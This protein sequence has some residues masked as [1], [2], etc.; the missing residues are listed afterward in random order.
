MS[1]RWQR[2]VFVLLLLGHLMLLSSQEQHRGAPLERWLLGGFG[3]LIGAASAVV[4]G[5]TGFFDSVRLSG[6]LRAENR[7]LT[8]E[9]AAMRQEMVRLQ[10]IEAELERLSS[11]S[12]YARAAGGDSF[13]ANVVY[14]DE[15]SWLKTLVIH[16][17]DQRAQANQPVV[18]ELG[19]VGR[20]VAVAGRY[21]KVQL[22]N[23]PSASASAMVQR[24]RRQGLARGHDRML[25]LE[26]IPARGDVR[27]GDSVITAGLDGV[28]PRGLPLGVVASARASDDL[29]Q[30]IEVRPAVDFGLLDQVYVLL[31]DPLPDEVRSDLLGG[32]IPGSETPP[33]GN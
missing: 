7:E 3:P 28:Y 9:I 21:A 1:E 31:G 15:G 30:V 5:T 14:V 20:I 4:D 23:D 29:F 11:L 22:I 32:D 27:V 19:L 25:R 16:T 2:L 18:N 26:N 8:T 13:V 24:T 12:S 33:G 10:G 6:S 17:G